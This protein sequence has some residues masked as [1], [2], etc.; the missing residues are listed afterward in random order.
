MSA[1]ANVG[2]TGLGVIGKPIALRLLNAGFEVAVF[3]IRGSTTT[4]FA[5][6]K[7]VTMG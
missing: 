5:P 3:D 4:S 2:V 6:N 7:A 1:I